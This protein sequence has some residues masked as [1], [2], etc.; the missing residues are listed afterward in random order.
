MTT[1]A[2]IVHRGGEEIF[3]RKAEHFVVEEL[4]LHGPNVVRFQIVMGRQRWHVVGCYLSS[5]NALTI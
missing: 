5:I 1:K 2:L 4:C 3:Y